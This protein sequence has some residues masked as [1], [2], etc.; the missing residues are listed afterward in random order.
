MYISNAT[1]VD[2]RPA[3]I[4]VFAVIHVAQ[5]FLNIA[6]TWYACYQIPTLSKWFAEIPVVKR[7]MRSYEQKSTARN[8]SGKESSGGMGLADRISKWAPSL[9][10][11]KLKTSFLEAFVVR[12]IIKPITI[13]VRLWI[14]WKITKA[15][16]RL[17]RRLR[18]KSDGHMEEGMGE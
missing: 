3:D 5:S 8:K 6:V 17:I 4:P 15:L 12:L 2:L 10:S 18:G 1:A 14:N 11:D 9:D 16:G 7:R 13:P